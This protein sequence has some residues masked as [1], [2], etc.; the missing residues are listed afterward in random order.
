MLKDLKKEF[1]EFGDRGYELAGFG[2]HQG[3]NDRVNQAFNDEYEKNLANFIRDIRKD[4][5]VKN[6]PFVIAETGMSGPEEKHPRAL[7]LMKA[8]AAVAEYKE[9][10][11]NVAF[12]GT[13]A[14]WRDKE[15][16]ADRAGVP[17][18]HQRRDLLPHR[19]GDG[20]RDEE[21]VRDEASSQVSVLTCCSQ[22]NATTPEVV[23]CRVLLPL[24]L[25]GL[26]APCVLCCPA[27]VVWRMMGPPQKAEMA[28]YLLVPHGKVDAKYNAGFSMYVAA[29]PLLKNYPGQQ[30]QSGL[31]GTWMFAQYDGPKPK[32]HVLRHRRRT[33]LVAGHAV[34]HRDAEVHHGR[35]G[36]E[37][38]RV[39]ERPRRRQGPR[40]EEARGPLRHRPAQPVGAL[41]AGRPQPQAGHVRGTVRVRL[42][43]AA[44]HGAQEDHRGQGRAD[45]EPVLD[46]VPQHRQLQGAGDVLPA[47]LLVAPS[48]ENPKLAGLF[49]DTRPSEPNKAVQMETQH[50]PAYLAKDAKGDTYARVAPTLFPGKPDGDAPLIH[51]ITAYSKAALWDGVQAWFDGGPAA[52]GEIDPKAAARPHLR[53]QGR[54][55]LADLSPQHRPGQEGAARLEFVRHPR[56]P[57]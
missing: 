7:S 12:V 53:R 46:A 32:E 57:R 27:A 48:V 51:R 33:R 16:V 50:I 49:L 3:W 41:A 24:L 30:F 21:A 35:R 26:L 47:V 17:L 4:L 5:G 20:D 8:Q 2:W 18:E 56:R 38:Q 52:S 45:R 1:P 36:P 39:G 10:K 37:L 43:A 25:R 29:W 55:D 14:F 31:F 13:K 11:G 54:S 28:G 19:R 15:R 40:L 42:P 6:L 34:R 9:F 23:P 22:T 44:A